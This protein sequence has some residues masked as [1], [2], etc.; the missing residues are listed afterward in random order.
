MTKLTN[1]TENVV[2]NESETR[3]SKL[4]NRKF[5]CYETSFVDAHEMSIQNYFQ[6]LI[7]LRPLHIRMILKKLEGWKNTLPAEL[8]CKLYKTSDSF[9]LTMSRKELEQWS[10][11]KFKLKGWLFG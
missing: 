8:K 11:H 1:V 7:L 5:I 9:T 10:G 2:K 4:L 3:I 6:A